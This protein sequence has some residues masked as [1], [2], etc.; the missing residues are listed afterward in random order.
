MKIAIS[1]NQP[2]CKRESFSLEIDSSA[3]ASKVINQVKKSYH[4]TPYQH[5]YLEYRGSRLNPTDKIIS[6]DIDETSIFM[7]NYDGPGS[8][9]NKRQLRIPRRT[10]IDPSMREPSDLQMRIES[11]RSIFPESEAPDDETIKMALKNSYWNLD[12]AL[13]FLLPPKEKSEGPLSQEDEENII[14]IREQNGNST[15]EIIQAYFACDKK[16]DMTLILLSSLN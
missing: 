11:I 8:L 12:R 16:I 10:D 3:T 15:E 7:M 4:N 9:P 1:L 6:Q 13:D 2:G 14:K 5:Y